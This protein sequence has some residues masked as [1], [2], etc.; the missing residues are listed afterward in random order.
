MRNA[1]LGFLIVLASAV[2]VFSQTPVKLSFDVVSIKPFEQPQPTGGR[3]NFI[4]LGKKGGPGTQDPGRITWGAATIRDLLVEAYDVKRYQIT[5]PDWVDMVRWEITAKLPEGTTKEQLALMYQSLLA[6]RFAVKL[7]RETK[8]FQ[9]QELT[10]AKGGPRLKET[11]IDP[12]APPP[13]PGTLPP[14]PPKLDKNGFPD[15]PG[16]GLM[17]MIRAEK[18][19]TPSGF[20]VGKGQK[21]SDLANILGN[22]IDKPVIDKTGLTAKYDFNIQFTPD[23]NG[24]RVNGAPVGDGRG[25]AGAGPDDASEPGSNMAAAIQQQL[26]LKLTPAKAKLDV[27]VVDSAQKSPTEN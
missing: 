8:E 14:G 21:M 17:T 23:M 6:D 3:G 19:G 7:H 25:P 27:I 24:I 2:V 18:G 12:N 11:V 16:P 22:Q 20:M 9:V 4:F 13:E 5:A 26:G 15:L 1:I 10:V